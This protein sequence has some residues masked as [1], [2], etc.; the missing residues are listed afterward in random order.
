ME[1]AGHEL[2]P[3][4]PVQRRSLS[5]LTPETFFAEFVAARRPVLLRGA[6]PRGE[7]GGAAAWA[8]AGAGGGGALLAVA[9]GTTVRV[10]RREQV[11]FRIS[12]PKR[13]GA[14]G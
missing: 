11:R 14:W 9:G 6:L 12:C 1:Y 10:E 13:G 8:G 5:S 7:F 2:T 3:G 4:E